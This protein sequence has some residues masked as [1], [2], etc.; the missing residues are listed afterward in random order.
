MQNLGGGGG[1]TKSIMVF[2]GVA[3]REQGKM[4]LFLE[5]R[6]NQMFIDEWGGWLLDMLNRGQTKKTGGTR[7]LWKR[8]RTPQR[9]NLNIEQSPPHA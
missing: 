5:G 3:Y 8:T 9:G 4:N 7:E 2:S 6:N 1:Q